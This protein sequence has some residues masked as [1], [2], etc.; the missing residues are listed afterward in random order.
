MNGTRVDASTKSVGRGAARNLAEYAVVRAIVGVAAVLPFGAAAWVCT[1]LMRVL[2]AVNPKLRRTGLRN[3][4]LAFPERPVAER[5]RILN[6]MFR[7]LGRLLAVVAR[8]HRL[9]PRTVGRY[10]RYEGREHF[11]RALEAGRGVLFFTAHLGNWELSAFAHAMLAQPMHVVVRPLDNPLLDAY[12]G[13]L[14][15]LSGNRLIGKKDYARSI[16]KALEANEAVGILADQNAAPEY[17]VFVE[18]FGTPACAHGGFARL[19][20][21]TG[22]VVIPGFA[23]WSDEEQRYVLRFDAPIEMSGQTAVDTQRLHAHL[24]GVIREYPEQWLWIHR[25]WKTRP[26]GAPAIY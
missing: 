14:R 17:G 7:S 9:T 20:A 24:E 11:D 2:A 18:F 26:P 23:L 25:R 16:L 4:E 8:M 22:A 10:I 13:R 21:H 12:A 19:A 5:E 15:T 6:G 3:L 1:L